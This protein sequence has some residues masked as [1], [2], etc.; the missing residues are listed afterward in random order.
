[1]FCIALHSF[2]HFDSN[3]KLKI[4]RGKL[5]EAHKKMFFE[6]CKEREARVKPEIFR[7]KRIDTKQEFIGT[8]SEFRVHSGL[9]SQ[10][11]YNLLRPNS[12]MFHCKRWGV[13]RESSQQFSFEKDRYKPKMPIKSCKFCHKEVTSGN[14]SRWH[15]EK[16]KFKP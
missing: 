7:F 9:T 16:C 11:V 2:F 8:R 15:G 13:F 14:F 10:E 12:K 5:Y 6:A 3:R 1:M 4:T